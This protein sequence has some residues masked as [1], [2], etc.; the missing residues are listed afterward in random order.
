MNW[1]HNPATGEKWLETVNGN[2]FSRRSSGEIFRHT[3][4]STFEKP[5]HLY[6]IVGSD[7]GLLANW[8]ARHYCG[9]HRHFIFIEP[10]EVLETLRPALP[11]ADCMEF[12]SAEALDLDEVAERFPAYTGYRRYSL[13]RSLGVLDR[14]SDEYGRLWEEVHDRFKLFDHEQNSLRANRKFIDTQLYNVPFNHHPV[15]RLENLLREQSVIILGGGPTLDDGI[16]WLKTHRDEIIVVAVGRIARRLLEEGIEPDFFT[17]VD[18]NEVSYDNSKW[19]TEFERPVLIHTNYT[20]S[21][22]LAEYAGPQ[23]FTDARYPWPTSENPDNLITQG[24]T[25]VNTTLSIVTMMGARNIYLL[26]VDFCYGAS[27]ETHES[28]SIESQQGGLTHSGDLT[29]ETYSSRQAVTNAVFFDAA[30]SASEFARS[31]H[32]HSDS[33][34]W[35]L[36]KESARLDGVPLVTFEQIALNEPGI[37]REVTERAHS[38][39]AEDRNRRRSFLKRQQQE[40]QDKRKLFRQVQDWGEEG[41]EIARKLFEDYDRLDDQTRRITRIKSKLE[42]EKYAWLSPFLYNYA[43]GNYARFLS[44][45]GGGEEQS[46]EE[47]KENLINYFTALHTTAHA[48]VETLEEAIAHVNNHLDELNPDLLDRVANYW[49]DHLQ[50]GR[51]RVWL[52]RHGISSEQLPEQ[53]RHTAEQLLRAWR[54]KLSNTED[55]KLVRKLKQATE[56]MKHHL[57]VIREAFE[58][59][60]RPVLEQTIKALEH[61]KHERARSTLALARGHLAELEGNTD[62]ALEHYLQVTEADMMHTALNRIAKIAFDRQD[63]KL[64]LDALELL[65]RYDDH[66]FVAY[67]DALMMLGDPAGAIQ[68]YD[69]YL[70]KHMDDWGVW[71]KAAR[72]AI[73]GGDLQAADQCLTMVEKESEDESLVRQAH[74]LRREMKQR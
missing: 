59:E 56:Q 48:M 17:S 30:R 57:A 37:Q 25:V 69:H 74:Q 1:M 15:A 16:D 22:L 39:L 28:K 44:P 9:E 10:A 11:D 13:V 36:G 51:V 60:N 67:A 41:L 23:C 3:F 58:E 19:V 40:L 64:A 35:Q 4:R 6:L 29:L 49:R 33:R 52:H 68:I 65:T 47:I 72:A 8:I 66:Y 46:Q 31:L 62:E 2:A 71:L 43:M 73:A 24:P 7:S 5:S 32:S 63:L 42:H 18:P 14:V 34:I 21:T 53:D 38:L 20:N 70:Q 27:G 26:G 45:E 12:V 54:E 50:E 61:M 55:S